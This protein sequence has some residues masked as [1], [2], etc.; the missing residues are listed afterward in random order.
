VAPPLRLLAQVLA[1][2]LSL[3]ARGSAAGL[4]RPR[5]MQGLVSST[6]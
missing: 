2:V 6:T 3:K 5:Q 4:H 1:F